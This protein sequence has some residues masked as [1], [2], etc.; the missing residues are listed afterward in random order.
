[1]SATA[2]AATALWRQVDGLH[3]DATWPAL[4]GRLMVVLSGSQ[5]VAA[6]QADDY[7]DA[8][9]TAQGLDPAPLAA[10]RPFALTGVASDG[11]ELPS[12]LLRPTIAVKVA[13]SAGATTSRAMAVGQSTLDMIVRT[14]VADAGRAADQVATVA[15]PAA[16]GWVRMAVGATCARCLILCGRTY[17]WNAGFLRHPSDDCITIPAAED[18]A[19]DLR[20]DPQQAFN[21]LPAPEQDRVFTKAGAEA[22]RAGAD[23]ALVV[24]ARRGM[25]TAG[26]RRFTY[27]LARSRP[28]L[29]PEQILREA[30]GDREEAVRLL[31]LHRYLT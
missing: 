23:M 31:R 7:L 18:T 28:R 4:A 13:V 9:L 1:V 12:L 11:R 14:Q 5:Q 15:R 25:Y 29:M 16:T 19:E 10:V 17:E 26:G 20:T 30:Q 24:N 8:V 22:I 2:K 6:Q 27:E 3:L 21:A